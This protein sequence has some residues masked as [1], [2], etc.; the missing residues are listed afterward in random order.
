VCLSWIQEWYE[1]V[2]L[3]DIH[4][5]QIF[6]SRNVTHHECIFPYKQNSSNVSWDY[7]THIAQD[8]ET[9]YVPAFSPPTKIVSDTPDLP[10]P[11]ST[12]DQ[13]PSNL[14]SVPPP[15]PLPDVHKSTRVRSAPS[16]LKDYILLIH[17]QKQ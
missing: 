6:V 14:N 3:L 11:T 17:H 1:E 4:S 2:I 13:I 16:Y 12:N 15:P 8:Y 9:S 10:I 7:H 5:K